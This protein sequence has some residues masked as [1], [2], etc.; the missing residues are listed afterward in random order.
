MNDQKAPQVPAA[1]HTIREETDRLGFTL[2]SEP[3]TGSLLRTLAASKPGRRFLELGTGVGTACLENRP[4]FIATQLAWSSGLMM[5][6][7]RKV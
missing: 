5:V 7:R 3:R 1:L 4:G 6:V 2:A